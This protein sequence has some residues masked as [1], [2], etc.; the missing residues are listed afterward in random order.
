M[1]EEISTSKKRR[2]V[3]DQKVQDPS[4]FI[5]PKRP[6]RSTCPF[7][8]LPVAIY[9][10]ILTKMLGQYGCANLSQTC[11]FMR[12]CF[13][14]SM[15]P[16]PDIGITLALKSMKVL[17]VDYF[18]LK[19]LLAIAFP[20]LEELTITGQQEPELFE[21]DQ[22]LVIPTLP[23]TIKRFYY[24]MNTYISEMSLVKCLASCHNNL[25]LLD[26]SYC[27]NNDDD[28][29]PKIVL[30]YFKKMANETKSKTAKTRKP[31]SISGGND[32]NVG[33]NE[34][35][36]E[37]QQ[38]QQVQEVQ[39]GAVG[40]VIAPYFP[41]LTDFTISYMS[42]Y[43][44]LGCP[45]LSAMPNL[46][47]LEFVANGDSHFEEGALM[48]SA[49][50]LQFLTIAGY[51]PT[52]EL[53]VSYLKKLVDLC[54]EEENFQ[55]TP[56]NMYSADRYYLPP[57]LA[58]LSIVNIR[59]VPRV[60]FFQKA[61]LYNLREFEITT[62]HKAL[63]A[64]VEDF[65]TVATASWGLEKFI[66]HISEF[67]D[68]R[69]NYENALRIAEWIEKLSWVVADRSEPVTLAESKY[70]EEIEQRTGECPPRD[71]HFPDMS[72]LIPEMKRPPNDTW[73]LPN[74]K[75]FAIV[76]KEEMFGRE[77]HAYIDNCPCREMEVMS[78]DNLNK[79]RPELHV[80]VRLCHFWYDNKFDS[81][82]PFIF[83]STKDHMCV[84][85]PFLDTEWKC[86]D[87]AIPLHIEL[88]AALNEEE[89]A[90]FKLGKEIDWGKFNNKR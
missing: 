49:N 90:K 77:G 48:P 75:L 52:S 14:L 27:G 80:V 19:N 36:E 87:T 29:S 84:W 9:A 57:G 82:S 45:L 70:L 32:G 43:E 15:R 55:Y 83:R 1:N 13:S 30:D 17:K 88:D 16:I 38:Q 31:F 10:Y 7:V 35:K 25:V 18:Y 72:K 40:G 76:C 8:E 56:I 67:A 21:Q 60:F 74:L 64:F 68:T 24:Y 28:F 62:D 81:K 2:F 46:D 47:T 71:A 33:T 61:S 78:F 6:K 85:T 4:S 42:S 63:Q 41:N 79:L 65:M 44:E 50:T 53:D 58:R 3:D 22:A 89:M 34:F 26:V 11:S 12:R 66:M 54:I 69:H 20:C 37:K 73:P 5:E 86:P 23:S 59:E 39:E 51:N